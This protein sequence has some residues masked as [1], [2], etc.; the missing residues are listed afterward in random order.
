MATVSEKDILAA[1]QSVRDPQRGGDIVTLG[2]VK[3]ARL[4][5]GQALFSIEV[6]P[7]HGPALEPLRQQAEKAVAALPGI[8]KVT[9]VLTAQ[10]TIPKAAAMDPHGMAKNPPLDLPVRRIVAVA[11]GKGGVGKSTVAFNLAVALA[12]TGLKTGLLDADIYGPSVPLLAGVRGRKPDRAADQRIMPLEAHGLKLMSIGFMVED[13]APLVWRGPMVQTA[14]YQMLR[15]VAWGSADAPLDVL[16]VDMPPGTG[17]AQLTLAQKVNVSGAV[18]VS[19]PQDLALIDA[20]KAVEMFRKVH[21]PILGLIENMSFY[22]CPS[23]GHEDHIFGHGGARDEAA[24]L[25]VPFLG[26]IPLDPA[27]RAAADGGVPAEGDFYGRIVSALMEKISDVIP[28]Q[29]GIHADGM[30]R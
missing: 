26:E 1:L 17:D 9:A 8:V 28:A 24:K 15:D 7:A 13:E 29:A 30:E 27:I 2:M 10:K 16:I 12:R 18:I 21:V 5:G 6:D 22:K 19:T 20:R 14:L 11:S 3:G 23:C 4:E 25:N